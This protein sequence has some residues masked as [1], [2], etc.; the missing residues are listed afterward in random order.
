M[1]C[2]TWE[3]PSKW[4]QD[5]HIVFFFT[6]NLPVKSKLYEE[7]ESN[8][9]SYRI[10]HPYQILWGKSLSLGCLNSNKIQ[11]ILKVWLLF[12]LFPPP[13]NSF[14]V[15]ENKCF[16]EHDVWKRCCAKKT[17]KKKKRPTYALNNNSLAV[18][19]LPCSCLHS[20]LSM[21]EQ[22]VVQFPAKLQS[23][24]LFCALLVNIKYKGIPESNSRTSSFINAS[25]WIQQ[26]NQSFVHTNL[27]TIL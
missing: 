6:Q 16:I 3:C 2:D 4:K 9:Q 15:L 14:R 24:S 5:S 17:C 1:Q 20:L 19:G 27:I 10:Y 8:F 22:K 25:G 21:G 11:V 23:C 13:F 18:P 26:D 7:L 12:H